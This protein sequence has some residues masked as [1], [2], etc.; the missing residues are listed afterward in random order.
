MK[1]LDEFHP[2]AGIHVPWS[3]MRDC[4]CSVAATAPPNPS[5]SSLLT[6]YTRVPSRPRNL[7]LG[8]TSE[9]MLLDKYTD[10][11]FC[12]ERK[13]V[14]YFLLL[15]FSLDSSLILLRIL[16]NGKIPAQAIPL[17]KDCCVF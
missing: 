16:A 1:P 2:L 3:G 14:L 9:Y 8:R 6:G 12:P 5:Q 7:Y 17:A 11:S 4:D 10:P 13:L 15:F